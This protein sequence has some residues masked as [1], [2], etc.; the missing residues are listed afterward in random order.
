MINKEV[1]L[2]FIIQKAEKLLK[3][4]FKELKKIFKKL[5]KIEFPRSHKIRVY[6]MGEYKETEAKKTKRKKL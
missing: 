3:V 5:L 1:F 4:P 2:R 6:H